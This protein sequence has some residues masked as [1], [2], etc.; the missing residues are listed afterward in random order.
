MLPIKVINLS[1]IATI[2]SDTSFN[3]KYVIEAHHQPFCQ[4]FVTGWYSYRPSL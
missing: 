2:K 4:T 3:S 1:V